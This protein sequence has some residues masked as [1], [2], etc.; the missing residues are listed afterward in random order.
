MDI[1]S[2]LGF[3]AIGLGF[4]LAFLAYRLLAT[5]GARERPVYVYMAFCL[6]LL[7]VGAALQYSDNLNKTALE[8]KTKDYDNLKAQGDTTAKNLISAQSN[9]TETQDKLSS[10]LTSL[11][12]AQAA[13]N[14]AKSENKRLADSMKAIVDTL[15]PT[16]RPLQEVQG[17]ITGLACSGG[18]HG[19]AMNGGA[20]AGGKIAGALSQISAATKIAQQYVP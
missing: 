18:A 3:G 2:I 15:T 14:S 16:A 20:E 8:Q 4:L 7:G 11:A 6:A 12:A 19:E 13:L 9:L 1:A 17:L 10:T 5:G